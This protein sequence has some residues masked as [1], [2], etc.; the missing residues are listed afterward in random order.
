[1]MYCML[2][3]IVAINTHCNNEPISPPYRHNN[4]MISQ[5]VT[6]QENAHGT[7]SVQVLGG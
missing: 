2:F 5:K 3:F 6:L 1:M 4:D 7:A